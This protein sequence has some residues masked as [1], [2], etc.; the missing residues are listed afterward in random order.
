MMVLAPGDNR[1]IEEEN[2][3]STLRFKEIRET[4]LTNYKI[5][6]RNKSGQLISRFRLRLSDEPQ[7][8]PVP[9]TINYE[10]ESSPV[11]LSTDEI[12]VTSPSQL[13][14]HGKFGS[15]ILVENSRLLKVAT[16]LEF[17][18]SK[19][20]AHTNLFNIH[21]AT[22]IGNSVL[23]EDNSLNFDSSSNLL[24]YVS[25]LDSYSEQLL[26]NLVSQV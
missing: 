6:A 9:E 21:Q 7:G 16:E 24:H 20:L 19:I 1:E 12:K 25:S 8:D 13:L 5:V 22:Q 23:L 10:V 2:G 11:N 4:D 14:T 15:V 26:M 17:K 18:T 3:C